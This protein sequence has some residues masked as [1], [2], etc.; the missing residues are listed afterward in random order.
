MVRRRKED[1]CEETR[2]ETL[3]LCARR[4]DDKFDFDE[5]D[6]EEAIRF[7]CVFARRLPKT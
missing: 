7:D 6:A 5:E 4:D 2:D 3:W 1:L